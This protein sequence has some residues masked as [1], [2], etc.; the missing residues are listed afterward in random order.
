MRFNAHGLWLAILRGQ[1]VAAATTV[2]YRN[3]SIESSRI[4]PLNIED[5]YV[6]HQD[7]YDSDDR[8]VCWVA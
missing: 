3:Q 8:A 7:A 1:R 5:N 2:L 4:I 6:E